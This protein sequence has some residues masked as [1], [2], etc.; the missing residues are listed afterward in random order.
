MRQARAAGK[1]ETVY[2]EKN[3]TQMHPFTGW[4]FNGNQC[5]LSSD[6]RKYDNHYE[7]NVCETLAEATFFGHS[8]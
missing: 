7:A 8:L 3:R 5:E 2:F 1:W 4:Y 6:H